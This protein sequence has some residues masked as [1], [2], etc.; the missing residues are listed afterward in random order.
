MS[1]FIQQINIYF[2]YYPGENTRDFSHED[3]SLDFFV[4]VY[5][6]TFLY[7]DDKEL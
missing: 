1:S 7:N 4:I 5:E 3:E 6:C 2:L